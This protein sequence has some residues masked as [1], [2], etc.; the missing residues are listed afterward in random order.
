MGAFGA[1][2][3]GTA[4]IGEDCYAGLNPHIEYDTQSIR[5]VLAD[6]D[7]SGTTPASVT[8]GLA[9]ANDSDYLVGDPGREA[10]VGPDI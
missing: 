6:E 4:L 3:T 7:G 8:F 1:E 5:L 9:D 2:P 10:W